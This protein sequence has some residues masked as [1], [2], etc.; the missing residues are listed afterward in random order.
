[1]CGGVE[2]EFAAIV[3]KPLGTKGETV[4]T[5]EELRAERDEL[6]VRRV[7]ISNWQEDRESRWRT[8][9]RVVEWL[10][11]FPSMMVAGW[12][13]QLLIGAAGAA[14]FLTVDQAMRWVIRNS[15]RIASA[16]RGDLF[17]RTD[18]IDRLLREP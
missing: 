11:L 18:E 9:V 13:H 2:T 14:I 16:K 15:D 17:K 3:T 12:T 7:Q 1:M 4:G 10:V 8:I 6:N 5:V